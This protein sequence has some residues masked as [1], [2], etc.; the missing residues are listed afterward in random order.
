MAR[1]QAISMLQAAGQKGE[2]SEIYGIVIENVQKETLSSGL[3]SQAYTGN[4]A[5]GSVEFKRFVNSGSKEYGTARAAGKGDA[6]T[7]PPTTVNIN[8]HREIVEEIAKFDLDT[9]GV[10]GI[11]ARRAANHID[12]MASELDTA[13]FKAAADAA[14]A[15]TTAAT[16]P[17]EQLEEL[18]LSVE[19]VKNSYVKGVNR[20]M[21]NVVVSPAFYS[22]VRTKLDSL[23]ASNV[24]TAAEEFATYHG[25]KVYSGLN[26]PEGVSALA[27][28]YGAVAMPVVTNQYGDPEKIPLSN[29]YAVSLFYDYGAKALTP[30][31]IFKLCEKTESSGTNTPGNESNTEGGSDKT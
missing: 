10:S 3:K 21:I 7:A 8:V 17:L 23:P 1:T 22:S 25:A 19:T 5:A 14:T 2:L 28:V 13:F 11:L 31:L 18:I 16:T 30:D 15:L 26:L 4:P 29:D 9:F 20:N 27:M 6:I 12:T 24:D